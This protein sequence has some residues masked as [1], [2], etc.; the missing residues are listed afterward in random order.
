MAIMGILKNKLSEARERLGLTQEQVADSIG[1]PRHTY[2]Q[3]ENGKKPVS[4]TT[5]ERIAKVLNCSPDLV[6]FWRLAEKHP[7]IQNVLKN[8]SIQEMLES[9]QALS[10]SFE[11]IS[12]N[13]PL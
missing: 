5:L 1:L 6:I 3:I 10:G 12:D 11:T 8:Y 2:N 13:Q 4:K 9:I 7:E